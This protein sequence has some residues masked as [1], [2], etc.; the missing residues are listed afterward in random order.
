MNTNIKRFREINEFFETTGFQKRTD[1]PEFFIF[2]FEELNHDSAVKMP[3]YQKDFYQLSLIIQSEN[4]SFSINQQQNSSQQNVLYFLSPDHVFSW[5]R[6][7]VTTGYVCYFK[8]SFL[9]FFNGNIDNDFSFFNLT[10]QNIIVLSDS[11][12]HELQSDF[13]KLHTELNIPN[14]YR[15]QILQSSLLSLLFKCK[16]LDENM[17]KNEPK[18]SEKTKIYNQ[19]KNLVNNCFILDKQ[20]NIYADKLAVRPTYLNEIVK[21]TTGRTAKEVISERVIEEAK[22]LL[23]YG[24]ED[25]AQIAFYLGFEEP[26]NFIRFFKTHTNSTPKDYRNQL[27]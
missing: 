6:D 16:S 18:P 9:D 8:K 19:F 20:V 2:S 12:V 23:H 5:K 4:S 24:T 1:I 17:S 27:R 22:K 7:I 25:V 11:Q 15:T 3:P 10:E 26:T 14:S 21:E 13:R